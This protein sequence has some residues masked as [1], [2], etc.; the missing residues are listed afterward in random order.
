M[1]IRVNLSFKPHL[2]SHHVP[3]LTFH[4]LTHILFNIP[5]YNHLNSQHSALLTV[6][7]SWQSIFK[8]FHF[9]NILLYNRLNFLSNP[10]SNHY[11]FLPFHLLTVLPTDLWESHRSQL[12]PR[13]IVRIW[14]KGRNQFS[15]ISW[16]SLSRRLS[17]RKK[18]SRRKGLAAVFKSEALLGKKK[19]REKRTRGS[20]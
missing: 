2:L 10:L 13:E 14:Q 17:W 6:L 4:L 3:S 9:L 8:S 1:K 16:Q 5:P 15:V 12:S 18:K 11:T 20:I 7:F 19:V